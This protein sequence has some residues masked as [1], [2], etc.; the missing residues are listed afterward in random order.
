M[1]QVEEKY[2]HSEQTTI[3]DYT[4]KKPGKRFIACPVCGRV[5]RLIRQP[6]SATRRRKEQFGE[7]WHVFEFQA[8]PGIGCAYPGERCQWS[9]DYSVKKSD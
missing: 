6:K 3:T 5:G 9:E 7:I 8:D 1:T 4:E 2:E